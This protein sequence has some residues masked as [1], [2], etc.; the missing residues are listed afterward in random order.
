MISKGQVLLFVSNILGT[1]CAVKTSV[2]YKAVPGSTKTESISR[3]IACANMM[4]DRSFVAIRIEVSTG[5]CE[6][7]TWDWGTSPQYDNGFSYFV[8]KTTKEIYDPPVCINLFLR[9]LVMNVFE[10]TIS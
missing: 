9:H 1:Y 3:S 7:L 2:L 5:I 4:M 8:K 6:G 10:V